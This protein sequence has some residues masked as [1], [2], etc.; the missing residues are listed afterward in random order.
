MG[1]DAVRHV[2]SR[3]PEYHLSRIVIDFG[4]IK[5][6]GAGVAGI[7]EFMLFAV[8]Q[9]HDAGEK[10]GKAAIGIGLAAIVGYQMGTVAG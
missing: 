6:C 4:V 10:T 2:T 7:V 3:M 8:Y 1:I 5:P 9:F